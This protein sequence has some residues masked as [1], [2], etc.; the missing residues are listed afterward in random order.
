LTTRNYEFVRIRY[1]VI[2]DSGEIRRDAMLSAQRMRRANRSL[3]QLVSELLLLQGRA[4]A[5]LIVSKGNLICVLLC[6]LVCLV[7]V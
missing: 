7:C 6:V 3:Q 1:I 5:S 4:S 2:A